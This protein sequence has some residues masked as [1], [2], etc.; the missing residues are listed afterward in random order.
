MGLGPIHGYAQTD[1]LRATNAASAAIAADMNLRFS[2]LTADDGLAQNGVQA[3]LQDQHGILWV[4][5][6]DGL[7]RFDGYHF[8]TYRHDAQDPTSLQHNFIRALMEDRAGRLWIAMQG[9]GVDRFDPTTGSFRH[10][11][12]TPEAPDRLGAGIFA[13]FQDS[14]GYFWFGGPPESGL[15]KL[16]VE[17][18]ADGTERET[19]THYYPA[20]NGQAGFSG[21]A[22]WEIVEDRTGVLWLAA[23]QAL[24]SLNPATEE[25]TTYAAAPNER[26]L[27]ALWQ[28]AAGELW[29]GGSAGLYKFDQ[30]TRQLRHYPQSPARINDLRQDQSGYFW[31]A[32]HGDGLYQ[33]EPTTA[34]FRQA[35]WHQSTDPT[36]LS[37]DRVTALWEDRSGVLWLGTDH[38][39]LNRVAARQ[40]Q[41][42]TWQHRADDAQTLAASRVTALTGV[43]GILWVATGGV[44]NRVDLE[45]GQISHYDTPVTPGN[46]VS[47][48]EPT[49]TI[50]A[51]YVDG[52]GFLWLGLNDNQVLRFDP[53][54]AEFTPYALTAPTQPRLPGPPSEVVGFYEDSGGALWVAVNLG[55][56]YRMNVE[57][58]T[59]T[60]V[61]LPAPA[62]GNKLPPPRKLPP[63][64]A[65]DAPPPGR[66]PFPGGR[67]TALAG[68]PD[69][70]LWLGHSNGRLL[71]FDPKQQQFETALTLPNAGIE[72]IYATSTPTATTEVLWVGT[73]NGL[74]RV[75]PAIGEV[76]RYTEQDGL[77]SAL[78]VGILADHTG[79]LWLGTDKGLSRFAP[80]SGQF[81]NF[82]KADGLP[83][84][85]FTNHAAWPASGGRLFFGGSNGV[86]AFSPLTIVDNPYQPPVLLTELLLYNEPVQPG[87]ETPLTQPIWATQKLTLR[88]DQGIVT[89]AF[90][91]LDYAAPQKNRYRYK[92]DGLEDAWNSVGSDRRF[93][94]YTSLPAG[95]YTF[96]V[97]GSNRDGLWSDHE[98]ALT[99]TMLPPWWQTLWFR[100]LLAVAL[101]ALA[102][103][104]YQ[105]RV[106]AMAAQN[107]L[108]ETQV[109]QRTQSLAESEARFR[110]LATSAFEA[111]L[112]HDGERVIDANQAASTLFA[113]P[114]A[115][116][117]GKPVHELL[118]P[119]LLTT[120]PDQTTMPP[121]LYEVDGLTST[122]RRIPLEVRL[123]TAPY[124]G[125]P[126]VI[127]ALYDLTERKQVESQ[128]QRMAALEE[129]E[130][131]GRELH[132]DLGQVMGY[133]NVQA[134]TVRDLLAQGQANQ[135]RAVL[136]QL[137]T[138]AQAAH[139]D[140]RHYIL[141][142]RRQNT[143]D[144]ATASIGFVEALHLYVEQ[145]QERYDLTVHVSLPA[146]WTAAPLA[147]EVETQLLRIIQEALTNV[148][149][150]AGVN[151]AR[152]L[153]TQHPDELQVVITDEG[154]GFVLEEKQNAIHNTQEARRDA[155]PHFG[156]SIMQERAAS[157]GGD[158]ELRSTPGVGTQVIVHLPRQL[159]VEDRDLVRGLRVLL[160]DDHPLYLDGLRTMLAARGVQV[161]GMARDGLQ[162]Q[163]LARTLYPDLILMDV[164]MPICNGLDATRE[165]K[166]ALPQIK[167][168]MLTV[169][170]E[171]ALLFEALK[172]GA[173]GYLL[174]NLDSSQFFHLLR[175]VMRGETVLSPR[176]A[177]QVLSSFAQDG[178]A[179]ASELAPVGGP[180]D[181]TTMNRHAGSTTQSDADLLP[182]LT[183]RQQA[184]LKLVVQGQTNKEIAKA[185]SITERTVKYHI[186]LILE[187]LQLRSRYELARYAQEQGFTAK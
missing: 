7:S 159:Q 86:V 37:E 65:P 176:L 172:L 147:P 49:N 101:L 96:R 113:Y 27:A 115:T 179:D 184:V 164:E 87:A 93:A 162:A 170:A 1:T 71:R 183:H 5:T 42:A 132:D 125:Q 151:S 46:Q 104:G 129:R 34:R 48:S 135:A 4:G 94:T 131:I 140:V 40:H 10:Y 50:Y 83:G 154:T 41:F 72:T 137:V 142:I 89:F 74:L 31:I 144:E 62:D 157:I 148:R 158:V 163:H 67:L 64:G 121:T 11:Q 45:S 109:A 143:A 36:S 116:L 95:H 149:K 58:T 75:E 114:H 56:L 98:V 33:F 77:P 78:I 17:S 47:G 111:I 166:Q 167:I 155:V 29:V 3:I 152:L 134:Q 15:T 123:R 178:Q 73:R 168:V 35:G 38:A 52:S 130:R 55:D 80:S 79:H 105:W 69:G 14:Q 21:G 108:L 63:L 100:G 187:R 112:I 59:I 133:M 88:H 28:D 92:L 25:F 145:L 61:P 185:L 6:Q 12:R 18:G 54:T 43:D 165:I 173:S 174:K 68:A 161:V 117:V 128:R 76:R 20:A 171:E 141:G 124:Q 85:E 119:W 2:G 53:Q 107:R 16:V 81:R 106:R 23:D 8:V 138:V 182:T 82:D 150:H 30:T 180:D 19:F 160:V 175:E 32:T 126:A 97:Q 169:A 181:A 22:I 177:T 118:T 39:G 156:L 9:G 90:A 127:T 26:R 139:D 146:G 66:L 57:R 110:E 13:L 120:L 122:G 153:F 44:L 186:G 84:N 51:L 102:Y 99:L 60:A 70:Q 136:D 91:A 103:S 24:V